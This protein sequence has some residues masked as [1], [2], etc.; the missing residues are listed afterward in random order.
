LS[1]II[2][3]VTT[4]FNVEPLRC[5]TEYHPSRRGDD[6]APCTRPKPTLR[7]ERCPSN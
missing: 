4:P 7:S 2:D 3:A 1:A 6:Y 5:C